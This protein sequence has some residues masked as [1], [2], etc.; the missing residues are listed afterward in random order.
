MEGKSVSIFRSSGT[1][2]CPDPTQKRETWYHLDS[3]QAMSLLPRGWDVCCK[4]G[5]S[6]ELGANCIFSCFQTITTELYESPKST[7]RAKDET[8]GVIR[9]QG[10]TASHSYY[11][12]RIRH[13]TSK[14]VPDGKELA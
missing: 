11:F 10:H 13:D 14:I 9:D 4:D 12:S 2:I 5:G 7:E 8:C 1:G 3:E 6:S